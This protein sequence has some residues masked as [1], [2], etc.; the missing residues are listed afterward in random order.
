MPHISTRWIA[1]H[2]SP[3]AICVATA[4]LLL[5]R[6]LGSSYALDLAGFSS[7]AALFLLARFQEF[8][9]DSIVWVSADL[10]LCA[11]LLVFLVHRIS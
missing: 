9:S 7:G 1:H 11:P 5:G 4:S 6:C 10:A 3:L 2:L 8:L